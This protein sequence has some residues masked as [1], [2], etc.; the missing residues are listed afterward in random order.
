MRT[1]RTIM[2]NSSRL[3]ELT[4]RERSRGNEKLLPK[5]SRK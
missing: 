1:M 3:Q 4:Q 2:S 5:E